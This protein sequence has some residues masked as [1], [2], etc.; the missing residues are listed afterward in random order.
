MFYS[1]E[2]LINEDFCL[3]AR[4]SRFLRRDI[5]LYISSLEKREQR[6]QGTKRPLI[7]ASLPNLAYFA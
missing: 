7:T 1:R 3:L 4:R 2:A 6:R 5:Y